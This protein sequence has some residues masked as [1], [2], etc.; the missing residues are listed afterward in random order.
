M[1]DTTHAT[2]GDDFLKTIGNEF[3]RRIDREGQVLVPKHLDA[4]TTSDAEENKAE[5]NPFAGLTPVFT[6]W[7]TPPRR[8]RPRHVIDLYDEAKLRSL[9][10][11]SMSNSAGANAI[12]RRYGLLQKVEQ[13]G[14]ERSAGFP[15]GAMKGLGRLREDL[16]H[17]SDAIEHIELGLVT[18]KF[19]RR[20]VR[21]TPMLLLGPAGVGKSY[22]AE[23]LAN[24]L[25]LPVFRQQMDSASIS[26]TLAGSDAVWNSAAS[27][28]VFDALAFSKA[29]NPVF[30][31]D[32]LDKAGGR[33]HYDPLAPLHGLLE[34]I[35]AR[36]FTDAF[37]LLPID[38]SHVIW[39]ATA[40]DVGSLSEPLR[41]RFREFDIPVPDKQV[42]QGVVQS[43]FR[44]VLHGLALWHRIKRLS[45]E[46]A[47]YLTALTPRSVRV[48]L[49]RA[50]GRAL[51][52][53]RDQIELADVWQPTSRPQS[54]MGFLSTSQQVH[55]Q[56]AAVNEPPSRSTQNGDVHHVAAR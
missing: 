3:T 18:A 8:R 42:M 20:A 30:L 17:F 16:P 46:A 7:P 34:P 56:S 28:A 41:S 55:R 35:T 26:A 32:E 53:D 36:Q 21:I 15:S 14:P 40:N 38:A 24:A 39:I 12:R 19:S 47:D 6:P 48:R 1:S 50:V 31:L 52:S 22:F 11:E 13:I 4:E 51:M 10:D 54:R 2:N 49:E 25:G 29:A 43:V 45:P 44:G 5:S 23:Q 9:L 27:G 37:A 33:H